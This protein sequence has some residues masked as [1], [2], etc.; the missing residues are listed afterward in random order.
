[1]S[2]PRGLR[3]SLD[4]RTQRPRLPTSAVAGKLY[5]TGRWPATGP[6]APARRRRKALI[7][8]ARPALAKARDASSSNLTVVVIAALRAGRDWRDKPASYVRWM[9]PVRR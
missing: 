6:W 3:H 9:R 2:K 5:L 7:A 1:M 8:S 4:E